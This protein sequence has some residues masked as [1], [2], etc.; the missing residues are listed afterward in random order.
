MTPLRIETSDPSLV[1]DGLVHVTVR[2]AA[3]AQ[4]V[5]L[6]LWVP[7]Q[8]AGL[9]L[10]PVVTLLHGVYASHWAWAFKGAAHR[11]AARMIAAGEI[12]PMVLA[13]PSDGL[14][15]DGS[16]YVRHAAPGQPTRDCEQWIVAEVPAVAAQACAACS[17]DSPQFIAGLSMGGWGALRL[18]GKHP[19]RYRAASAHSALSRVEQFDLFLAGPRSGWSTAPGDASVCEALRAASGTLPPLRF[20]CGSDDPLLAAN[21]A[22]HEELEAAGIAHRYEEFP[23]GHDWP[24][25]ALHLQDTLRFFGAVLAGGR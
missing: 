21:R 4:R 20:D 7:P 14:W 5:D 15:G 2:S 17:S 10:L 19:A 18:A 23:G 12:P 16:G 9:Q 8:A 6:T 13:M 11:T 22:L 1:A 25:W 24:Y 3:L